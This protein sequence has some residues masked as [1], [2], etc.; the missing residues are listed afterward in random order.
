MKK[1]P[2]IVTAVHADGTVALKALGDSKQT[3]D[4]MPKVD[5]AAKVFEPGW[6][7]VPPAA[8]TE[9]QAKAR[10]EEQA[11]AAAESETKAKAEA[12]QKKGRS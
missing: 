3:W 2:A 8:E 9:E 12:A 6:F 5:P 11:K 10:G 4:F 7:A 1:S